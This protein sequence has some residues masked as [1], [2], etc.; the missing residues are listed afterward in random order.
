MFGKAAND[1]VSGVVDQVGDKVNQWQQKINETILP[2]GQ[3][4]Q[5]NRD[6]VN[7]YGRPL[8]GQPSISRNHNDPNSILPSNQTNSQ[9]QFVGNQSPPRGQR[10]DQPVSTQQN[11]WKSPWP[12]S[13]ATT[14]GHNSQNAGTISP[15]SGSPPA[16][17]TATTIGSFDA[18]WPPLPREEY[19]NQPSQQHSTT[20]QNNSPQSTWPNNTAS[21]WPDNK[22]NDNF[23]LANN[24]SNHTQQTSTTNSGDRYSQGQPQSNGPLF[25]PNNTTTS[26]NLAN[27][28]QGTQPNPTVVATT[29]QNGST[30]PQIRQHMLD[31][32]A[33]AA[34][35]T[36]TSGQ[37][38]QPPASPPFSHTAAT[39]PQAKDF[40]WDNPTV[41]SNDNRLP[42]NPE[43]S[44]NQNLPLLV[45]SWVILSGSVS[46][47]AYLFWSFWDVRNKYRGLVHN[48]RSSGGRY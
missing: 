22:T 48:T 33:D 8:R 29:Q 34:V 3:T 26:P 41:Q 17:Q 16:S 15:P 35:V 2:G 14:Q 42:P 46:G 40:G 6:S 32:P 19:Q 25:P 9:Q 12:N 23:N 47:N 45:L 13:V 31:N 43:S 5:S 21:Q 11:D 37:T 44:Q 30:A 4:A 39:P 18:P 38:A 28:N 20:P 27:T 10:L 36:S 7:Q 24:Q 1:A